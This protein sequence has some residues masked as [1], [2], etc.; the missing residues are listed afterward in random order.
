[1]SNKQV[2]KSNKKI[3]AKTPLVFATKP[4][5]LLNPFS[6]LPRSS[7]VEE[8]EPSRKSS[9]STAG[10][11]PLDQDAYVLDSPSRKPSISRFTISSPDDPII[12]DDSDESYDSSSSGDSEISEESTDEPHPQVHPKEP[13]GPAQASKSPKCMSPFLVPPK[14]QADPVPQPNTAS[15]SLPGD[16]RAPPA[17][18][19]S[20]TPLSPNRVTFQSDSHK[21]PPLEAPPGLP[22]GNNSVD[23]STSSRA[24]PLQSPA[25][26]PK[27]AHRD[28][29]V[30]PLTTP[31]VTA[32]SA[33][34]PIPA[35]DRPKAVSAEPHS[36]ALLPMAAVGFVPSVRPPPAAT[37][38]MPTPKDKI[39]R[40]VFLDP[41]HRLEILLTLRQFCNEGSLDTVRCI[42]DPASSAVRPCGA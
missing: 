10:M 40:T 6:V 15:T 9:R 7:A 34:Q 26:L 36:I 29:A 27:V 11:S 32:P 30:H 35:Q 5:P 8:K 19:P 1:M 25:S 16:K 14:N 22:K 2:K 33:Q 20:P 21:S 3:T 39:T 41:H 31:T 23:L 12:V 28:L 17:V 13:S 42:L 18:G 38:V 37:S 4:K 24:A